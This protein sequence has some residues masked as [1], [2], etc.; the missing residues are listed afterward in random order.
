[1]SICILHHNCTGKVSGGRLLMQLFSKG[2]YGVLIHPRMPSGHLWLE[3][4]GER[5]RA[6]ETMIY[7]VNHINWILKK[8]LGYIPYQL[9]LDFHCKPFQ[10]KWLNDPNMYASLLYPVGLSEIQELVWTT[11][12][13]Q[14]WKEGFQTV[15]VRFMFNRFS[16]VR[17]GS[18][19]ATCML[20]ALLWNEFVFA[21]LILESRVCMW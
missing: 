16:Y 13:V 5:C 6:Q 7:V 9:L 19:D 10:Q 4:F 11:Y 8:V 21:G 17:F 12:F 15:N 18:V 3:G 2:L 1:M 14:P 20:C